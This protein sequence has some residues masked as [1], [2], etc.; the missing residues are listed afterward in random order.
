M[1]VEVPGGQA[2]HGAAGR[3]RRG[4]FL[5]RIATKVLTSSGRELITV[6]GLP[7]EG[8]SEEEGD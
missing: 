4:E 3:K 8:D 6:D 1:G 7:L 5:M 2:L